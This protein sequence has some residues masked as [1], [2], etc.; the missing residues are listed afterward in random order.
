LTNLKSVLGLLQLAVGMM[1]LLGLSWL[2]R[3]ALNLLRKK[4]KKLWQEE[5]LV[6]E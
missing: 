5:R 1:L 6:L 3:Q 4:V 2:E